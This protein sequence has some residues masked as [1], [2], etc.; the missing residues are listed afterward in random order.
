MGF[1]FLGDISIKVE[2]DLANDFNQLEVDVLKVAHHGSATSSGDVLL[3]TYRPRWAVISAGRNN[4][5]N[6]PA[7]EVVKRLTGYGIKVLCTKEDHAVEFMVFRPFTLYRT[8]A[9]RYGIIPNKNDIIMLSSVKCFFE[10]N[11]MINQRIMKKR[12]S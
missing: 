11:K 7:D 5:F 3:S 12:I 10:N 2:E 4:R 9:G 6:H 1:L 8:A